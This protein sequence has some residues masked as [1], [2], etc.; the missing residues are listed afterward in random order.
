MTNP[1]SPTLPP[2]VRVSATYRELGPGVESIDVVWDE[3]TYSPG[4]AEIVAVLEALRRPV[5]TEEDR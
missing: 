4:I 1:D 2:A 5:H 3:G